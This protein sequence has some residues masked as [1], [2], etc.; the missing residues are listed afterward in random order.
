L[1]ARLNTDGTLDTSFGE[2][3]KVVA[4][5]LAAFETASAVQV[6]ADGS[7]IVAGAATDAPFGGNNSDILIDKFNAS[8]T[9]VSTFGND[10]ELLAQAPGANYSAAE[11]VA[12][13]SDGD[14]V[15]SVAAKVG[16]A[17]Q[18]ASVYV[19]RFDAN[20]NADSSFAGNSTP[21]AKLSGDP[22]QMVVRSDGSILVSG[23][24]PANKNGSNLAVA[25]LSANGTIDRKF[26]QRGLV[27]TSFGTYRQTS[28]NGTARSSANAYAVSLEQNGTIM[29]AGT[30]STTQQQAVIVAYK[31][32]G[33]VL[34]KFGKAGKVYVVPAGV[35]GEPS[36]ALNA[37]GNPVVAVN[38]TGGFTVSRY[39]PPT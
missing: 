3:G 31:A 38:M 8:G 2:G 14:V 11:G 13:Q 16:D 12:I 18:A 17:T 28:P 35:S 34:N 4:S 6:G 21:I 5:G 20:G 25:A 32:N 30:V 19:M 39:T 7:I 9:A 37:N 27:T 15:V 22:G 26:G 10:G 23:S 1:I 36:L 24:V 33:S 29:V